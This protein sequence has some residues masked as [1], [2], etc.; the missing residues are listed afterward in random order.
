MA[1][2]EAEVKDIQEVLKPMK[3]ELEKAAEATAGMIHEIIRD[4]VSILNSVK[5]S[6]VSSIIQKLILCLERYMKNIT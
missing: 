6:F 1:N 4:T 3:L 5:E 2:T